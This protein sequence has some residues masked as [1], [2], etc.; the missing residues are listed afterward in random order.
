MDPRHIIG[1]SGGVVL[2]I[3]I[4]AQMRRQWHERTSK[5]VS[6]FLYV[7]QAVA[8]ITLLIYSYLGRDHVFVVLNAIM[9]TSAV[10]GFVLW[11]R[12]RHR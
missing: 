11:L 3:M 9:A 12:Y 2:V 10:F 4:A 6:P 7:L 5:G 8:S 1:W